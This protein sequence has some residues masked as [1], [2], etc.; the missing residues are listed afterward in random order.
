[1]NKFIATLSVLA[2]C[3]VACSETSPQQANEKNFTKALDDYLADEGV[4]IDI[5]KKMPIEIE[6]EQITTD[7]QLN[8]ILRQR[9]LPKRIP[10]LKSPFY[11]PLTS[12]KE[13]CRALKRAGLLSV[14][15]RIVERPDKHYK[16]KPPV[17]VKYRIE[18]YDLTEKGKKLVRKPDQIYPNYRFQIATAKVDKIDNFTAPTQLDG[19]TISKVAYTYSPDKVHDWATDGDVEKCFPSIKK[20]L[21]PGKNQRAVLVLMGDGWQHGQTVAGIFK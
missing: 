9:D 16:V 18:T 2:F 11:N 13:R 7:A 12:L 1:V 14:Q 17:M 8:K 6:A 15:K 21:K 20:K 3:C 4:S 19:Y 10:E 5:A